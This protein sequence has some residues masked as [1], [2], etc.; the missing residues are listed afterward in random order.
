MKLLPIQNTHTW[1]V[2]ASAQS[3]TQNNTLPVQSKMQITTGYLNHTASKNYAPSFGKFILDDLFYYFN[4]RLNRSRELE[5]SGQIQDVN[6]KVVDDITLL[7]KKLGVS[8]A[9]AKLRYE[10]C[11][12]IGGIEPEGNGYEVGLNKVIGYNAEKLDL[13][14]NVVTP[15]IR[16]GNYKDF[17]IPNGVIFYGPRGRGKSYMAECLMEH[18]GKKKDNIYTNVI[19]EDW[20]KGDTDENAFAIAE[21]FEEAK[22]RYERDKIRTVIYIEGLDRLLNEKNNPILC[23][24]FISAAADCRKNGITWVGTITAPKAMPDWLFDPQI[25]SVSIPVKAISDVEQSAVMSYFW[26]KYDRLDKSDHNVILNYL[27][28]ENKKIYPPQF[29]E[30]AKNVDKKLSKKDYSSEKRGNYSA[31]V[32]TDVVLTAI[33]EHIASKELG[34]GDKLKIENAQKEEL[35]GLDDAAYINKI[36]EKYYGNKLPENN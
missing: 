13:I 8:P 19:S 28:N 2:S 30:I 31:P 36:Q 5:K 29:E 23:A 22:K 9:V 25:T 4:R 11:L 20:D 33:R 16:N 27:R 21:T 26:A 7:S 14:Q 1:G 24:E 17:D 32:T 35:M 3:N 15:I 18:F 10:E 12:N 6:Q 34:I